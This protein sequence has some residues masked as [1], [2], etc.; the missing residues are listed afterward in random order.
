MYRN[1]ERPLEPLVDIQKKT[2]LLRQMD[3]VL[4]SGGDLILG[5]RKP[6][7]GGVEGYRHNETPV[8]MATVDA[9]W[10]CKFKVTNKD[11]ES[12]F[13]KH[14]RSLHSQL[15][16][17]P[18]VDVTYNEV[19]EYCK[20]LNEVTGMAFRLPNEVEWV[21]AAAPYGWEYPHGQEPDMNAGHIFNDGHEFGCAPVGD[22]RWKPNF[23]GLDQIGYNVIEMTQGT[24]EIPGTNGFESDGTYYIAKGGSWGRCKFSPGVHRRRVFDVIDR[25]PRVGFRLAHPQI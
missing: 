10:I 18:V 3:F 6:L 2:E 15:D 9:F 12:F 13:P 23:I 22:P 8:H 5:T 21:Y 11:F 17:H 16:N 19:V 20:R 14:K 25:N 7:P 24:Y 4:V 1:V